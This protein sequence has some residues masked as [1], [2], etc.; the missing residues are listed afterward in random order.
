MMFPSC[1]ICSLYSSTHHKQAL[2]NY[3]ENRF[4][5][6]FLLKYL[7]L[8]PQFFHLLNIQ[9]YC[10]LETDWSVLGNSG[11]KQRPQGCADVYR[12]WTAMIIARGQLSG[13]YVNLF[14]FNFQRKLWAKALPTTENPEAQFEFH[15]CTIMCQTSCLNHYFLPFD[16]FFFYRKRCNEN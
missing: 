7:L 10:Q 4:V 8:L 14:V 9:T 11:T 13:N 16:S 15:K 1:H 5:H 2:F 3:S 6:S 12:P